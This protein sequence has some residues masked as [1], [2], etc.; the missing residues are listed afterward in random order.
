MKNVV[1]ARQLVNFIKDSKELTL[2]SPN[3]CPYMN[4]IGALFT[5]IILQS[6][7]NY[8]HIVTPRVNKILKDYPHSTTVRKFSSTLKSHGIEKVL[9]WQNPVKIQRMNKLI[10]FC[11]FNNLNTAQEIKIFLMKKENQSS[12]LEIH[13]IGRKT[14]DYLLKLLNSDTIAVDRH[15]FSFVHKAGIPIYDY[16]EVKSVVEY[17][18]DIM[19]I[20]RRTIDYS[21]WIYMSSQR[22]NRQLQISF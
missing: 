11:I 10:E 9:N 16:L 1:L 20:S 4:H 12:F 22:K 18:A 14:L 17:A 13:G 21:I 7:V 3:D 2:I 6:G 5:D 15:I 8:K 19:N